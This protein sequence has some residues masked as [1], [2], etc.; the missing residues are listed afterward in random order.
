[1]V[2]SGFNYNA[3]SFLNSASRSGFWSR[4]TLVSE[5]AHRQYRI[6]NEPHVLQ[7]AP[8]RSYVEAGVGRDVDAGR[9]MEDRAA[10]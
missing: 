2:T 3:A 8:A 7:P 1:M 6:H 10:A 4:A 5:G 9:P